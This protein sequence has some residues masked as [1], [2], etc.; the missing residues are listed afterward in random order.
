MLVIEMSVLSVVVLV[1]VDVLVEVDE[2]PDEVDVFVVDPVDEPVVDDE[3]VDVGDPGPP[4]PPPAGGVTV[5]PGGRMT[6]A[7]D[8]AVRPPVPQGKR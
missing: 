8:A 4:Y 3:P 1:L 2:P 7:P 6:A 5:D